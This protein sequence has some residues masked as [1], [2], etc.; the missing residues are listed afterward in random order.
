[1]DEARRAEAIDE[2]REQEIRIMVSGLEYK[3]RAELERLYERQAHER[4]ELLREQD[5][6]TARRIK[7]DERARA[8]EREY[9]KRDR[10]AR[11]REGPDRGGGRAR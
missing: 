2:R 6:D 7:D 5:K 8:L 11:D 10:E 1:M 9:E 3:H 4:A